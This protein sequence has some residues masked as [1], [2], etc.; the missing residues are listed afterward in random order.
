MK[1]TNCTKGSE[2]TDSLPFDPPRDGGNLDVDLCNNILKRQDSLKASGD[3]WVVK[4]A[5]ASLAEAKLYN[6]VGGCSPN[7]GDVFGKKY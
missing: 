6:L 4:F 7:T 3:G 5:L 2:L 1:Y